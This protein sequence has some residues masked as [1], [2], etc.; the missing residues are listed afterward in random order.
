MDPLII[1]SQIYGLLENT[2]IMVYRNNNKEYVPV[3]N[4]TKGMCVINNNHSAFVKCV[5][6]LKYNGL[7]CKGYINNNMIGITPVHPI[8]LDTNTNNWVHPMETNIFTIE[9][10]NDVYIY[11]F[12]LESTNNFYQVELHGG[13]NACAFNHGM[14][15]PIVYHCYFGTNRVQVD[16]EKHPNWE[17]GYIQL[18]T[19]KIYNNNY[20]I[21]IDY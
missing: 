3:Q 7:I 17:I 21:D 14:T 19:F 16:F 9:E 18:N 13:I 20:S 11:N 12:F 5:I 2:S 1:Q 4:I 15:E 8:L 6:K 10:V